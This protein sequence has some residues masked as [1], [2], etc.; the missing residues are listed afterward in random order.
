MAAPK[1]RWYQFS[2]KAML[3]VTALASVPFAW[4]GYERNE[5]RKRATAIAIIENLAGVVRFDQS[6]L[7]RPA[8]LRPLLGD[9]SAGEVVGV[10]LFR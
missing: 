4:L 2:L 7:F 1:R 5:V 8:W 10:H 3:V 6:R 9:N